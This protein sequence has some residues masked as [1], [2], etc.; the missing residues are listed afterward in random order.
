M[1]HSFQSLPSERRPR[2]IVP[3]R[4]TALPRLTLFG[5]V[6]S[7]AVGVRADWDYAD[8]LGIDL[9]DAKQVSGAVRG[10]N[11]V[12]YLAEAELTVSRSAHRWTCEIGFIRNFGEHL[13]LG[14]DGF[15]D[16]FVVRIDA[17]KLDT[18]VTPSPRRAGT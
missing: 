11:Y 7:G 5:L 3:V 9:S 6:D 2:P 17:A 16:Q 18:Q 4:F 10:I 13:L 15:F 14:I 8:A 1:K 12:A